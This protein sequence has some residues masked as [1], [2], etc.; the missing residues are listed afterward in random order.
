MGSHDNRVFCIKWNP[1][2][3]NI[4]LSGGWDKTVYFWDI[5]LKTSV[6]KLFGYYIGGEAIDFK[7]NDILL[8]NNLPSYPL[9]IYDGNADK[10]RS[11]DWKWT[12]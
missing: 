9:R 10:V 6:K 3:N 7:G 2:N 1:K 8:G 12:L 5:R 4:F 11:V